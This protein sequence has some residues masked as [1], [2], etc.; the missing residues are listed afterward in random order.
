[1]G[2]VLRVSM[3]PSIQLVL[4]QGEN[5]DGATVDET[6]WTATACDDSPTVSASDRVIAAVLGLCDD[7]AAAGLELPAVGGGMQRPPRSGSRT[8]LAGGP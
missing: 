1:M 2:M 5:A 6:E 7:T 3:A 8:R 4:L